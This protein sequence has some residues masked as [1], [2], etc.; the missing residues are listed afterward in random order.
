MQS[1]MSLA[2]GGPETLEL[3]EVPDPTPGEGELLVKVAVCAVNFPDALIIE[4]KYQ[5]SPDRPFAPGGEVA[6]VVEAVGAGVTEFAPGDR[7][8]ALTTW[9]GMAEKVVV[10]PSRCFALPDDVPFEHGACF[11]ITYGTAYHAYV[12]RAQLQPGE[13]VLITGAAGGVGLASVELAKAFGAR[14]VATASSEEKLSVALNAGAD[15]GVVCPRGPLDRDAMKAVTNK[16]KAACPGG[17][18][19]IVDCVGGDYT[20]AALRAVAWEGR[21]LV[22]GF[23]A[24]IP[25]LKANLLLLKGASAVGVF[26]G[27][28]NKRN[29]AEDKKNVDAL[30]EIYREGKINPLISRRFPL[31]E[32]GKAIAALREP[33]TYGKIVVDV[34]N[35]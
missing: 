35:L 9:G 17:A 5:F 25:Q 12:Q 13:T 33:T 2:T 6:G 15:E 31:A 3:R 7:V 23:P 22:I 1:L 28:F 29:P 26:Y 20:E 4:D 14:V 8:F 19:V 34:A 24:G 16:F 18:D 27:E 11:I 32:G 21:L 30:L 10:E